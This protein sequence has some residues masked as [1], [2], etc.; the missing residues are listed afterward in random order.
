MGTFFVKWIVME[1]WWLCDVCKKHVRKHCLNKLNE[2]HFKAIANSNTRMHMM[3]SDWVTL[4]D[5]DCDQ[6][7]AD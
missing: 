5:I 3:T 4:Y 7:P 2:L 6:L 1:H